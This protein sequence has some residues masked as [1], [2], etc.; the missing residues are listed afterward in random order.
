MFDSNGA[1]L[2]GQLVQRRTIGRLIFCN[3]NHNNIWFVT[4][5]GGQGDVNLRG[6]LKWV[7]VRSEL[8]RS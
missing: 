5:Q 6:V 8:L 2:I 1:I 4:E 3:L 7:L